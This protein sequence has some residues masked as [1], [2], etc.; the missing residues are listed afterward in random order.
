MKKIRETSLYKV[1]DENGNLLKAGFKD[2]EDA[3]EFGVNYL[4]K[5]TAISKVVIKG[6]IT[7]EAKR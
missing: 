6:E 1:E 3:Y 2:I 5:T 7:I 4:L